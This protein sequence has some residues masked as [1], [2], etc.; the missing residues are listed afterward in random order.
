MN[1]IAVRREEKSE[2]IDIYT[3]VKENL[4]KIKRHAMK[5]LVYSPYEL[6]EF[7]Q[8][9]YEA[10]ILA[11]RN[12]VYEFEQSFWFHFKKACLN[13]TYSHGDKRIKC[14]HE[15]Y[16]EF[17]DDDTPPTHAY[18]SIQPTDSSDDTMAVSDDAKDTFFREA[19]SLMTLKEREVWELL[20]K[21]EGLK[22]IAIHLGKSKTAVIKLKNA[23]IKRAIS[24]SKTQGYPL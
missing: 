11:E 5:Y 17:G 12:V 18:V 21:G 8:A 7:V 9:A 2:K 23:G 1:L 10:V 20:L 6:E 3:W 13:M 24:S 14:Y 4:P 16:R 22:K 15:E 19:L